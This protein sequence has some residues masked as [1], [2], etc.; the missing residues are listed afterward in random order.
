MLLWLRLVGLAPVLPISNAEMSVTGSGAV[1]QVHRR[2]RGCG[3]SN[4]RESLSGETLS[5]L[6]RRVRQFGTKVRTGLDKAAL[7]AP[8]YISS[9][10][11]NF[12]N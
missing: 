10:F 2:K 11:G 4:V 3:P 7:A 12:C 1:V 8:K 6:L 9:K 5:P